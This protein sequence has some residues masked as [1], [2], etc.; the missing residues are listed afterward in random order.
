MASNAFVRGFVRGQMSW[1]RIPGF[2]LVLLLFPPLAPDRACR[3]CQQQH[4]KR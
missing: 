3:E 2:A 4:Q 1:A